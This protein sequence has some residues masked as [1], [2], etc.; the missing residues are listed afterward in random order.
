MKILT[1]EFSR[2]RILDGGRDLGADGDSGE[3]TL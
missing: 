2:D 3:T 1:R